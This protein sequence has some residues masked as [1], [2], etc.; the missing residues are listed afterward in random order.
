[1]RDHVLLWCA[2]CVAH[3]RPHHTQMQAVERER[4]EAVGQMERD[5]RRLERVRKEFSLEKQNLEVRKCETS[6][7]H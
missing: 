1:M 6:K 3:S 7:A 2:C 4:D 5:T